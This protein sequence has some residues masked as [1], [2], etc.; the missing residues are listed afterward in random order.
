VITDIAASTSRGLKTTFIGQKVIYYPALPSTMDAARQAVR[1]GA[2]DGTV[3][4]AGEQTA[5]KG[6]LKRAWLSPPGSI[7][8]SIVLYPGLSVLPYL[9]MIASLAAV[10][11]IEKAADVKAQIK[12]P[13]DIL[14]DGK[15]AG[16]ILIENEVRGDKV[17]FSIIGI[18]INVDLDVTAHP[19]I[20][21]IATSLKSQRKDLGVRIIRSLLIEFERLYIKLPDGK[22]I[23]EDWRDRL[24]TLG[25]K[26]KATSGRQVTEGTAESV[27]Q[28]GALYIR[29][30]DGKLTKVVAGDVT[31]KG[32]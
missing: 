12:W 17:D 10:Y 23:F 30:A 11:A 27:D 1:Q 24:V 28:S 5:G 2:A 21:S 25:K 18:G 32:E 19:E 8:L 20:S 14:V 9:V 26:V 29:G 6:R 16:G 3:I 15:K 4:I 31:L 22:T 7:A 13:N